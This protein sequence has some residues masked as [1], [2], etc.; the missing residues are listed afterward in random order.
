MIINGNEIA[1][2]I[3][4]D[5]KEKFSTRPQKKICFVLF[6]ENPASRQY[7]GRKSRVAERLG[8]LAKTLEYTHAKTTHEC[9]EVLRDTLSE[10][11][12]VV[13]Q[14]PLSAGVDVEAVLNMI[15]QD[16]DIDVL[17]GPAKQAYKDGKSR[18][19]PPVAGAV[20][21][22]LQEH[23]NSQDGTVHGSSD[24]ITDFLRHREILLVGSGRLVGEPMALMF[25]R[26]QIPYSTID[27]NTL[28]SAR[29]KKIASADILISGVGKAHM[30][31]PEMIKD[32]VLLIDAGTSEQSGVLAGDIDPACVDKAALFTPVPGGV[33]PI[34]VVKLFENL[35]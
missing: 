2:K 32:G 30:I 35:L 29:V 31:K 8:I 3:E 25:D 14:L 9:L 22:I 15:P 11:D 33:G 6:N 23:Y 16:Q 10:Y 18:F 28:E 17:S 24:S 13:V 20:W 26:L 4:E 19:T 12:G 34:S 7:I 5:L 27:I 1:K 21:K